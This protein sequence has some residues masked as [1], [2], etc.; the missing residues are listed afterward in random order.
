MIYD[1]IIEQMKSAM[2]EKNDSK[3]DCLRGIVSEVKNR[4]VNASP[5][6][7][8]TDEIVLQVINKSVKQHQDSIAQFT[9][10]GR[11]D[12]VTKEQAEVDVLKVFLPKTLSEDE[13]MAA[14]EDFIAK[15]NVQKTKRNMG[16]IMKGIAQIPGMDK[17][18]ASKYL[19]GVLTN[20]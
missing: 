9:T 7:E 14:I 10:A 4:T 5:Q 8:I 19:N 1:D 2:R 12:L 15:N 6:K 16:V 17:G 18:I 11:T 13:I 20:G 3:R